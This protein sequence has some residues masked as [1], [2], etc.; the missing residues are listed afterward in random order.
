M[1]T[2]ANR[3]E[4]G[5]VI[6]L[7]ERQPFLVHL[8]ELRWRLLRSFLWIGLGG[9]VAWRAA[10]QILGILIRPAG[11]VVFLSP[12]EP[13]LVHLKAAFLG[14]LVLSC[15]LLAWE[16]WGFFRPA[17][18]VR[19]R[20]WVLAFL[21]AS[22]GLFLAGA[23]FGWKWLLPAALKILL[24]F[25]G[26]VM[27]PMLTVGSVVGFACW[28]IAGCGLIFQLPLAVFFLAVAG[29]V[30]PA[31]LLRH[32]RLAV[33]G[34]LI[35]AAVLTPTPDILTQ[36]LLAGPLAALY[37]VSIVLALLVSFFSR[38]RRIADVIAGQN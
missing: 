2:A 25:G 1:T 3:T 19:G 33:V 15:P 30:R 6:P 29:L 32:W 5:I 31:M 18:P 10:P 38:K 23:W 22:A 28:L 24:S 36:L 7:E 14:G 12:T 20:G 37:A 8:E 4:T 9:V 26:E 35:T 34:I 27:T 13:F 11:R 21:P 16:V 17:L